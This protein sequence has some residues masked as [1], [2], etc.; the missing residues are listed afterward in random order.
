MNESL[1]KLTADFKANLAE[2]LARED[3]RSLI[4]KTKAAD[5][6]D[7]GTFEVVISTSDFDRSGESVD[8]KGWN[9]ANYMA[10]PVVLWGHDY[11]ALPIGVCDSIVQEGNKLIAK[12]RFA[13]AE[14]NPFAQQVRRLYDAKIV[15]ATSVGFIVNEMEGNIITQAE[16]LEFSFVPVP[17]NPY[18][19][20]LRQV[21]ELGLDLS[22]IKAKGLELKAEDAPAPA[23]ETKPEET[24]PE[25][26]KPTEEA[27][28]AEEKPG[29]TKGAVSDEVAINEAWDKK[30]ENLEA[31]CGIID[32]F[33][34][35]Y[36]DEKTPVEAFET[37]LAETVA[38]LAGVTAADPAESEAVK[39]A[40]ASRTK[41][42]EEG[43][44]VNR[45]IVSK[46][47]EDLLTAIGAETSA[48]AAEVDASISA[49]AKNILSIVESQNGGESTKST[50]KENG[51]VARRSE[52]SEGEEKQGGATPK[53]KVEA[54]EKPAL[55][56]SFD[57]YHETR[58]LLRAI[59]TATT[60]ALERLN[61]R[62]RESRK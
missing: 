44:G 58:A 47:I 42:L 62:Q 23:P 40:L 4:E 49:H 24:K 45:Y 39:A 28:K 22:M 46:A 14:A 54:Q 37:L 56:G 8:Q 38:L 50:T 61:K 55:I 21:K 1:K 18:A 6:A 2:V 43:K 52:A 12:G 34:N 10:N 26:P 5:A 16:L 35:V 36:L 29:E 7:S 17:A 59:S 15:R 27:P 32:S 48:M 11:Y 31:V 57:S 33:F 13:P 41:A 51:G 30:W 19:L 25:E 60:G 53:N 3:Y 9:L 20:S